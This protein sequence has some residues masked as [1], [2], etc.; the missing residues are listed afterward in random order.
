MQSA[1]DEEGEERGLWWGQGAAQALLRVSRENT[2]FATQR[3]DPTPYTLNSTPYS[4]HPTPHTV[5]P[6]PLENRC[7]CLK[8][9]STFPG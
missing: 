2:D 1:A 5:H 7:K 8:E 4:L 6:T 3:S 9:S